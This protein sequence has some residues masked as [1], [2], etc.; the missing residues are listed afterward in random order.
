MCDKLWFS[1]SKCLQNLFGQDEIV[2]ENIAGTGST[3]SVVLPNVHNRICTEK[4][5]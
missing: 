5:A 1:A 3:G 2:A 4:T